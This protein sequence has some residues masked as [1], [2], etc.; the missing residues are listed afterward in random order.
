MLK[1]QAATIPFFVYNPSDG[2]AA[3]GATSISVYVSKDGGTPMAATNSPTEINASNCPGMYKINLTAN[4]MNAD[5]IVLSFSH[6]TY[7]AM[8]VTISTND[9]SDLAKADALSTV[10]TNIGT[11]STNVSAV[12]AKT[13]NLPA[14][15]ASA[16]DVSG[17]LAI[18]T[19]I[20]AGLFNW[21]LSHDVLTIYE[22]G[23]ATSTF[24]I[25]RDSTGNIIAIA[26]T[27]DSSSS[28]GNE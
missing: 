11:V 20:F 18:L 12:K 22:N 2:Q 25:S 1:N 16:T 19:K 8:P 24:Q 26:P 21:G 15:P 6:S 28:G 23:V 14:N 7:A 10:S 4:E 5:I 3:I 17:L 27:E 13:D 9:K